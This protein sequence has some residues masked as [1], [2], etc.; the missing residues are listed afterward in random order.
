[1]NIAQ[2]FAKNRKYLTSLRE[3]AIL[4]FDLYQ[5]F[6]DNDEGVARALRR[7][8]G[9]HFGGYPP[10]LLLLAR[11]MHDACSRFWMF[12]PRGSAVADFFFSVYTIG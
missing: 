10:G 1:M 9:Q 4:P 12:R 3:T 2:I 11:L 6:T 7:I 5:F 8:A